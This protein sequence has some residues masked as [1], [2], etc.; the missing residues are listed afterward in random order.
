MGPVLHA[1]AADKIV[2]RVRDLA[3]LHH[4]SHRVSSNIR[5]PPRTHAGGGKFGEFCFDIDND[6]DFLNAL[7]RPYKGYKWV[8]AKRLQDVQNHPF[9]PQSIANL[10]GR[11]LGRLAA[12][13]VD[14]IYEHME[15]LEDVTYFAITC[16]RYYE[17][18]RRHLEARL[19]DALIISWAGNRLICLGDNT[20]MDDLPERMLTDREVQFLAEK[21]GNTEDGGDERDSHAWEQLSFLHRLRP[22]SSVNQTKAQHG[23]YHRHGI[24]SWTS[25]LRMYRRIHWTDV[26]LLRELVEPNRGLCPRD[27]YLDGAFVLRNLT[28]KEYVR[29]STVYDL[30]VSEAPW[31]GKILLEHALIV[32][33]TWSSDPSMAMLYQ[34]P[35]EV[36]R[37]VWAGHRF[38]VCEIDDVEDEEGP[39]D[40]WRGA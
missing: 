16:Q 18:G 33:I 31:A 10:A 32:R 13:L 27:V 40:G 17:I 8:V 28:T 21:F 38:D 5:N 6:L 25:L 19:E 1:D 9:P 2:V 37:G 4:I 23:D 22:D 29:G 14:M 12:E 20:T 39:I 11:G 7:W 24:I 26:V 36:H 15:C 34:G 35:L 30:Y 3:N